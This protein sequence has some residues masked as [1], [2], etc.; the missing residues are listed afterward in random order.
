MNVDPSGHFGIGAIIGLAIGAF[1]IGGGA[2]VAVNAIEGKKDD[3]LLRGVAGSALGSATTT[4]SL[5]LAPF[6]GGASLLFAAGV[7][8]LT[9]TGVNTVE[10]GIRGEEINLSKTVVDFGLSY[11]SNIMANLAAD[12]LVN[13]NSGWFE[14]KKFISVFTKTYGRKLLLQNVVGEVFAGVFNFG[15]RRRYRNII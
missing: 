7:G 15:L 10:T 3:E 2:Q 4:L 5:L 13:I 14:P 8:A 11:V 1:V 9:Q 12:A 6:T